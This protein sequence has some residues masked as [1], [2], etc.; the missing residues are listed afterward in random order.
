MNSASGRVG[1]RINAPGPSFPLIALRGLKSMHMHHF[2]LFFFSRTGLFPKAIVDCWGLP[3]LETVCLLVDCLFKLRGLP[4]HP[5][6]TCGCGR[7]L[8]RCIG[9]LAVIRPA[10]GTLLYNASG[11]S[12]FNCGQFCCFLGVHWIESPPTVIFV[13]LH[14]RVDAFSRPFLRCLCNA[15]QFSLTFLLETLI[16]FVIPWDTQILLECVHLRVA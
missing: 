10:G 11:S 4:A 1:R 12:C 8:M 2:P 9:P 13:R 6:E 7:S 14:H 5:K 15:L 3:S 16:S